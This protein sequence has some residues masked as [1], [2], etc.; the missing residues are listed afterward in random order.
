M[1]T[2]RTKG[3]SHGSNIYFKDVNVILTSLLN[4]EELLEFLRGPPLEI[5]VHDRDRK[6][7][8]PSSPAIF[9]TEAMDYKLGSTASLSTRQTIYS[10]FGERRKLCDPCGIAKLSFSDL[11][12]GHRFLKLRL[13]IKGSCPVQWL[14]TDK[15]E[16]EG[17]EPETAGALD[18][19]GNAMPIG[20][21][22]KE[23]SKLTVQVEIAHPFHPEKN[24]E[25]RPFGRIIYIFKYN[26]V[27]FLEKLRSK[28]LRINTMAFQV[29]CYNKRDAQKILQ[30]HIMD[31]RDRENKD[32]NALTG[33]HILDKAQHIFVLEG[34]KDEAIRKLWET[35]PIR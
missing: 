21:Y 34:L 7:E 5:E 30:G 31:A 24:E 29:Y 26:N 17:N 10:P 23:N 1:P 20:H 27:A 4:Y 32:L 13:P 18:V 9:G 22:L 8:E 12:R 33:F 15:N 28:I 3:L 6:T 2:H 11:F 25:H 14:G 35:V 16:L 19:Q